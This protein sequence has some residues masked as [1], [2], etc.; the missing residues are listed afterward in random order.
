MS[1]P[2]CLYLSLCRGPPG[3]GSGVWVIGRVLP[4]AEEAAESCSALQTGSE[5][6]VSLPGNNSMYINGTGVK[7]HK[8]SYKHVYS[9][10]HYHLTSVGLFDF[11]NDMIHWYTVQP[12]RFYTNLHS[13]QSQL[14]FSGQFC[15]CS[16]SSG[17]ASDCSSAGVIT[18]HLVTD[19]TDQNTTPP[20]DWPKHH[21]SDRPKHHVKQKLI[22]TYNKN[23]C[24][25]CST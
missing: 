2:V 7:G 23:S 8:G 11:H 24:D 19:P 5:R 15:L 6:P 16:G 12:I 22:N 25:Y 20:T 21:T 13:N 4:K 17:G 3:S 9:L 18:W 10:T 14:Y 1:L